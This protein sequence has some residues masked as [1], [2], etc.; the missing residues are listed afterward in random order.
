[1]RITLRYH[2]EERLEVLWGFGVWSADQWVHIASEYDMRPRALEAGAGELTCVVPRLP[3]TGS[4][5]TLRAVMLDAR[6][7]MAIAHYGFQ[8]APEMLEVRPEASLLANAR[9]TA[10]TRVTLDV[11]WG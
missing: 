6:T 1:M 2:A 7:R 8:D 11:E 4:L 5:Y 10:D 9:L 3:L